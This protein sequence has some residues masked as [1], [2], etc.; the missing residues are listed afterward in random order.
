MITVMDSKPDC[1]KKNSAT[2]ESCLDSKL[3]HYIAGNMVKMPPVNA[4]V[5]Y[6]PQGH[7]E[8]ANVD[9][10]ELSN[11]SNFNI[12]SMILCRV[13]SIKYTADNESDEVYAKIRLIPEKSHVFD[14]FDDMGFAGNDGIS[15]SNVSN[16]E[17][18]NQF[19]KTLTQSD[20]NN[21][22]GFSVPRFCAETIFPS[23]DYD[24]EPPVQTVQIRDVHGEVWNF[25][26]IY[27]G[28]PRRHLLTTGWSNFVNRKKLVAGDSIVFMR[29]DS[30]D[31]CF[32]IRRGKK[33]GIGGGCDYTM[34][35][36]GP[37]GENR[38]S[39]FGGGSYSG[40][41]KVGGRNFSSGGE[42]R[43]KGM[44]DAAVEAANLAANGEPFEVIYYPRSSTP[45]FVVK[46]S[47]V[48]AS[49]TIAWCPG[50][51]YKMAFETEDSSRISWFMGTVSGVQVVDPIRWPNSPWRLLQVYFLISNFILFSIDN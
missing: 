47:T 3:W 33:G 46:A 21:G 19:A 37:N 12:P 30:G 40:N 27:R 14:D 36:W 29:D 5:V 23:L 38:G 16:D 43:G 50:M 7:I 35:G 24:A 2:R 26:H 49:M 11:F 22:G 20:A 1:M 45:E 41:N 34:G 17:K 32:G 6:F 25:R 4:L 13:V 10:L 15:H 8:H 48:R 28:T 18:P 51:R 31:L 42:S 39:S 44:V 9:N